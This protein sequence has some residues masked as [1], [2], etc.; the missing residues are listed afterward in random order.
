[1]SDQQGLEQLNSRLTRAKRAVPPPR[2]PAT[3]AGVQGSQS[4][5]PPVTPPAVPAVG[6]TA[7]DHQPP[8]AAPATPAPVSV[9]AAPAPVGV[10]TVPTPVTP[11]PS[12]AGERQVNLA[13]R[14]RQSLDQ[15]LDDLLH[16]LRRSGQRSSKAELIELMPWELEPT[17]TPDLL[18][19]L[20]TFRRA[21][22]PRR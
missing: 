8:A 1:V 4:I 17:I 6:E 11:V 9:P 3:P 18:A 15:R 12:L 21:A 7:G 10:P 19:R 20:D 13:V 16:E 14:V 5:A 2:R 22:G